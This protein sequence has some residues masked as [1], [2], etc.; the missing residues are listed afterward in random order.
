MKAIIAILISAS[1]AV[2]IRQTLSGPAEL[3]GIE[4]SPVSVLEAEPD[5][6]DQFTKV[7][8][9]QGNGSEPK[10]DITQAKKASKAVDPE[11]EA[12]KSVRGD[13]DCAINENRNWLGIARCAYGWECRGARDCTGYK[14]GSADGWCSGDSYC[15]EMGPLDFFDKH[16]DVVWTPGS[17]ELI[18]GMEQDLPEE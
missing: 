2:T 10:G 3:E 13:H 12:Y 1:M 15:P 11:W 9:G 5:Q 14:T 6:S 7:A 4:D 17:S 8:D 16:G 18:D